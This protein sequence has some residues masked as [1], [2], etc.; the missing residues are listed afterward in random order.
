MIQDYLDFN[1]AKFVLDCYEHKAQLP[2]LREQL[3]E[4]DGVRGIDPSKEKVSGTPSTDGVVKIAI[5]RSRLSEKI[6]NYEHDIKVLSEALKTLTDDEREAI[7]ICF[8]GRNISRQCEEYHIEERT[9]YYRR[10]RALAKISKA[11][12]G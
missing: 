4:T 5:L 11:I 8:N 12:I 3:A 2:A 9:L 1:V 6:K 7:D 10:K